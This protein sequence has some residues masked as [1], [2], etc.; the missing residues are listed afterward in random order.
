M[1][2]ASFHTFVRY[3][4]HKDYL[5]ILEK[6]EIPGAVPAL[7]TGGKDIGEAITESRGVNMGA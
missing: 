3:C 4:R 1:E 6:N 5:Q 7:V 2:V